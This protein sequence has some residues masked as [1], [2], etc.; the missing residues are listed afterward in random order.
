MI[1][2]GQQSSITYREMSCPNNSFKS[3][4][5]LN[6]GEIFVNLYLR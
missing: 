3:L 5:L 6:G 1:I 2:F 4:I